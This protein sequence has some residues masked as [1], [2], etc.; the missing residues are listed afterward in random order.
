MNKRATCKYLYY[1][2]IK[3]QRKCV[4]TAYRQN[5]RRRHVPDCYAEGFKIRGWWGETARA[6]HDQ[7]MDAL[8][9]LRPLRGRDPTPP[10]V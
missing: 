5:V 2:Y 3:Y 6:R 8:L 4:S 10:I 1:M 9:L 7:L